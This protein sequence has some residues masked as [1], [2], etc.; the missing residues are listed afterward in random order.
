MA[1]FEKHEIALLLLVGFGGFSL[2]IAG[3]YKALRKYVYR[4]E[5]KLDT[6]FDAGGRVSLSLTAVTVT[7]QLLWPADFMYGATL[8]SKVNMTILIKSRE[9]F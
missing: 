5:H 7:S 8:T 2:V 9:L 6:I 3:L 1:S 4:D